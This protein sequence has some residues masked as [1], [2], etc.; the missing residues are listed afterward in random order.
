MITVHGRTRQQFYKGS[1]DWGA[2]RAGLAADLVLLEADPLADLAALAR[3][4]H[5]VRR[6]EVVR[7]AA[8]P[9]DDGRGCGCGDR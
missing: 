2:I 5:V 4:R 3:V 8:A 9:A 7:V 6:G 1:A